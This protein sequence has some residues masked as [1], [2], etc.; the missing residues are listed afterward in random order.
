MSIPSEPGSP[1][2]TDPWQVPPPYGA[3]TPS[4]AAWRLRVTANLIDFSGPYIVAGILVSTRAF[5]FGY[6][7]ELAAIVWGLYNAYQAG[8]TG[9]S[10][11]KRIVGTRLIDE[12]TGEVIGGATGIGRYLLHILDA[13]PF[14]LGFLWPLWDTK[15]QTW[16]DKMVRSIVVTV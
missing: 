7:L 14:W 15:R 2:S 9:Q 11:G 3:P 16:A 12:R 6:V 13:L 10:T 8:T 4:Y 5:A 1:Q